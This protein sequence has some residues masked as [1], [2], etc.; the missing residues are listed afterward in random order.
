MSEQERLIIKLQRLGYRTQTFSHHINVGLGG[1]ARISLSINQIKKLL[2]LLAK[3]EKRAQKTISPNLPDQ[4]G[5]RAAIRA[6]LNESKRKKVE[7]LRTRLRIL[8]QAREPAKLAAPRVAHT[9]TRS[10][11]RGKLFKRGNRSAATRV[12]TPLNQRRGMSAAKFYPDDN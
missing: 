12:E 6:W 4:R 8:L 2:P 10:H 7:R 3:I 11:P 9:I 5:H 1:R